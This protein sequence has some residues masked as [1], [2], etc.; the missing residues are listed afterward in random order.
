M[1][2][3]VSWRLPT[4]VS[5]NRF[6]NTAACTPEWA[7]RVKGKHWAL[8]KIGCL[9]RKQSPREPQTAEKAEAMGPRERCAH[10][11]GPVHKRQIA[12]WT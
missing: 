2:G 7:L 3:W 5:F 8:H 4:R 1:R 11:L 12:A 9:L 10:V 6:L